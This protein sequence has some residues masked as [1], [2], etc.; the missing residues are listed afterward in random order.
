MSMNDRDEIKAAVLGDSEAA[1]T[2]AALLARHDIPLGAFYLKE[3]RWA[4]ESTLLLGCP[5]YNNIG[6]TL[7]RGNIVFIE[8]G[9]SGMAEVR[10]FLTGCASEEKKLAVL[11]KFSGCGE[12]G[13]LAAEAESEGEK[14]FGR[15]AFEALRLE[16]RGELPPIGRDICQADLQCK[17]EL[18]EALPGRDYNTDISS[19][20]IRLN[21]LSEEEFADSDSSKGAEALLRLIKS[22]R[23]R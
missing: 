1:V 22:L 21:G 9:F 10:R 8:E 20:E 14:P 23:G 3:R 17:G 13:A 19:F 16:L 18:H 7:R 11:V 5:S 2:F 6:E 12:G 15:E 4:L